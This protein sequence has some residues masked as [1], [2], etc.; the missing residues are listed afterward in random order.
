MVTPSSNA[1]IFTLGEGESTKD[2]FFLGF[3]DFFG[4][5]VAIEHEL[6]LVFWLIDGMKDGC[7]SG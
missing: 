5:R 4:D 1:K 2:V 3:T 7:P 6:G